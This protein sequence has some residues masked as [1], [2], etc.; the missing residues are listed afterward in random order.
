MGFW[1]SLSDCDKELCRRCVKEIESAPT[2]TSNYGD[3]K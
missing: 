2:E 3:Q 1:D